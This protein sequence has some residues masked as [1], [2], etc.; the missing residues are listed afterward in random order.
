MYIVPQKF[1][2]N[3]YFF[4][5]WKNAWLMFTFNQ[6]TPVLINHSEIEVIIK[7]K[8]LTNIYEQ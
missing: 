6:L 3:T 5:V 2:Q 4:S 8:G 1:Q 7:V